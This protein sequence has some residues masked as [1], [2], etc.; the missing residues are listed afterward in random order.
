MTNTYPEVWELD[1][2]FSG[3][4]DSA[5]LRSHLELTAE[6]LAGFEQAAATFEVPKQTADALHVAKFLVQT[7]E[8]SVDIRQA[9]AFIGCLMAQDTKDKKAALL[10]SEHSLMRSRFQSAFLKFKQALMET[11]PDLSL[12]HI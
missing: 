2:L 5:E 3:G 9:G 11:D 10:Q 12:I 4:S 8:V 7:S 1:S 6:K